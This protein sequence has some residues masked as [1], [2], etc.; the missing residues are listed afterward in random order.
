MERL[1]VYRVLLYAFKTNAKNLT[2]WFMPKWPP[3]KTHMF[4]IVCVCV[5][6]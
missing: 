1:T 6:V 2:A 3:Q 5:C 4:T